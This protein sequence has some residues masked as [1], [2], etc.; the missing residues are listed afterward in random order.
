MNDPLQPSLGITPD[1]LMEIF[2]HMGQQ[3]QQQQQPQ[4]LGALLGQL[5]NDPQGDANHSY[6]PGM[7]NAS[8][9]FSNGFFQSS[10]SQMTPEARL[11]SQGP[12]AMNQWG[13]MGQVGGV[14]PNVLQGLNQQVQQTR[15]ANPHAAP[16]FASAAA[17][18]SPSPYQ[19]QDSGANM[20]LGEMLMGRNEG[21]N[22][23]A[24]WQS[25]GSPQPGFGFGGSGKPTPKPK[26]TPTPPPVR[27]ARFPQA[28]WSNLF[29]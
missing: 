3:P 16:D 29:A 4:D 23:T 24:A 27:V 12:S 26:P 25:Q 19:T 1:M 2:K 20:T 10:A 18:A 28:G 8:N 9:P 14:D 7:N 21:P 22:Q 6:M 5:R 13:A 11:A 15:S 17:T